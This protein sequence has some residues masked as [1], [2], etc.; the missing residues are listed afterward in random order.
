MA[1]AKLGA[2]IFRDYTT[3]GNPASG[4]WPIN[5]AD[6]R[7]W[8]LEV[9]GQG[10][11]SLG[12]GSAASPVIT[13]AADTN[14]GIYRVGSDVIGFTT[15]GT[16]RAQIS[17]TA[18]S[19]VA[20]D[21]LALGSST[22]MWSDLFG[23][24]G[25]VLNLN[26]GNWVATHTT[27]DLEVGTGT[28]TLGN[29]G[30]RLRDTDASHALTITPGSNLTANRVLTITT[31]DAARALNISAA[32]VTITT[33]GASLIDDAAASN[34]R[35]TLGLAIGTDVQA[36]DAELAAL[37]GLTSAADSLPY[38][39]GSGTAAAICWPR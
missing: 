21:G 5:K 22:L 9:E 2:E 1:F 8:M 34:A 25:F 23:A 6:M 28:L 20:S 7:A 31:G 32:D 12:D 10:V 3:T 37:A 38:F 30:L 4:A 18:L 13:F 16:G 11:G 39:T 35:T 15:G 14:T 29:A 36:Y 24:A 33:F 27:G 26:N 19:P 17:T